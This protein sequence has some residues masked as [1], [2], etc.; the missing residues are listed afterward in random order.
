MAL[1]FNSIKRVYANFVDIFHFIQENYNYFNGIHLLVC[2]ITILSH[3][4][5]SKQNIG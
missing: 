1:L 5:M 2:T 3:G 4:I